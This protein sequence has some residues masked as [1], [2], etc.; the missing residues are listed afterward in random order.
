MRIERPLRCWSRVAAGLVGL[1]LMATTLFAQMLLG[2]G[3][4]Q[5]TRVLAAETML[6]LGESHKVS[7]GLRAL[8]W[9]KRTGFSSNRGEGMSDQ[10]FGHGGFTGTT[11]WIDP[12]LDLFVI[13]LSNRVHPSG[14]GNVTPLAGRIGAA[15]VSSIAPLR[16]AE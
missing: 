16:K 5:E 2:R 13:F 8:G 12:G 14:K 15:A 4:Y 1:V 6:S 11:L 3:Q 10:A 9:D 7:S